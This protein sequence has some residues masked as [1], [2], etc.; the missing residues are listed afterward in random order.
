VVRPLPVPLADLNEVERIER[1][2]Q[3][4]ADLG[5]FRGG[6]TVDR[7]RSKGELSEEV[8][9]CEAHRLGDDDIRSID[10]VERELGILAL[11]DRRIQFVGG[12]AAAAAPYSILPPPTWNSL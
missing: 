4:V 10:V 9:G 3:Y 12:E 11:E 7:N 8:T 6:E 5:S 1:G 2:L